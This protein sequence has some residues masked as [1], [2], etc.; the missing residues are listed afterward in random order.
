MS[1]TSNFRFILATVLVVLALGILAACGSDSE[2]PALDSGIDGIVTIGPSCPVVQDS[3]TPC[4]DDG[5]AAT[6]VI[7]DENGDEIARV[8][9]SQDGRFHI[10]LL[11]GIY[12]LVPQSPNPGAPPVAREQT[13]EVQRGVDTSVTIQYESGVR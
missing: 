12:T 11:P 1:A 9:S 10:G 13:V 3:G 7:E 2:V 8:D 4:P 5:F 6:I